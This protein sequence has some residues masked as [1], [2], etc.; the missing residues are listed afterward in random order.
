MKK[1]ILTLVMM[2]I[3]QHIYSQQWSAVSS[4]PEG[5]GITDMAVLGDGTLLVTTA[6]YNWPSVQGGIRRSTDG[7]NSWQN[8]LNAYN[9][10]TLYAGPSGKL[11]ASCWLYPQNEGVF[12]ST[13][14]GVNWT[15][16]FFGDENDNVFSIA[17]KNGDSMVFIGTRNGVYR[18]FNNGAWIQLLNGMPVNSRV[19]DLAID[20]S[21]IIA[22]ATTNGVFI[23]TNHGNFWQSCTGIPAGD[24]I[25]SLCFGTVFNA[26]SATE[27]K[28]LYAGSDD[29]KLVKSFREE[30]FY[31]AFHLGMLLLGTPV[32]F[33]SIDVF[34]Q[35]IIETQHVIASI[36][37]RP[38]G[39]DGGVAVS[40]NGG[41]FARINNGLTAPYNVSKVVKGVQSDRAETEIYCGYFNGVPNGAVVYKTTLTTGITLV[42]GITPEGFSLE[43]NYPNPFNPLTKINFS[44]PEKEFVTAK[45]YDERGRELETIVNEFLPAGKYSADWNAG[46]FSSGMYICRIKSGKN[47]QSIRMMLIK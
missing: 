13:N 26:L 6:S 30:A 36:Y 29:G 20:E 11:F 41:D 35:R 5:A 46:S 19:R 17:A 16:T 7:G 42:S 22:A 31:T 45:I 27:Q 39:G 10:R 4:I 8:V 44:V 40:K 34:E 24:T 15:Q 3:H 38:G 37:P 47:S 33:S 21:G 23:S 32:E 14:G 2:I 12:F 1:I 18:N 9:G 28:V 25:T 43:Q